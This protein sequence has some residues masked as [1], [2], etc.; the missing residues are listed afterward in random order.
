MKE[1]SFVHC[2][3]LHLGCRQF[4]EDERWE[5]FGRT[6]GQVVD[7]ALEHKTDYVL[8][9]GDLFHHRSIS[10]PTL[11]QA[12]FYLAKLKEAG[13][14]VIAIEGNHDKAFY[15][16]KDSWMSFLHNQ[17]YFSLLKPALGTEGLE[18][19]PYD[20]EKGSI[21]ST[22]QVRFVGLGYL[23]ATTKQRLDEL[24]DLLEPAKDFTVVLLHAGAD[25]L[26]GQDLAGVKGEVFEGL[27][28]KVDYFALG[29]IHSRQELGELCYNPGAPECVHIDE[30]RYG[31][32]KG[33]YHVQVKEKEK[34]VKF[35]PSR[36]RPVYRFSVDV[37]GI[38][39][40]G[41]AE[42][43]ALGFLRQKD[44]EPGERP[45]VQ[46]I[47]H[48]AIGFSSYAIDTKALEDR[49]RQDFSCLAAEVINNTN[50]PELGTD[51]GVLE[52]D[53]NAIERHV[54]REM[55]GQEKPEL[56]GCLDEM[57][58]LVLAVKRNVL[59]GAGEAEIVA[60][61]EQMAELAAKSETEA[62]EGGSGEVKKPAS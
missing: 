49:I 14:A 20:G 46:L 37:G 44:W 59:A 11:S 9:A 23:G 57:A 52:F 42:N 12:I 4:N 62:E 56:Q 47:L 60:A 6:F 32:E 35:I 10:A 28:D 17:G 34:K 33:F 13:I 30:E 5:D 61:L 16:E 45:I 40:P 26:L 36:R 3:D 58:E 29:H 39:D 48:G 50:L 22:A 19:L 15:L 54:I 51:G 43:R 8:I 18:L 41:Q 53:R 2:A 24:K 55:I 7:Y 38:T 21:L 27:A 1:F 31:S 25:K